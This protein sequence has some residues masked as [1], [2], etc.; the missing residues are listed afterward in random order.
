MGKDGVSVIVSLPGT[1][2]EADAADELSSTPY[3]PSRSNTPV[4]LTPI[5][6]NV[7]AKIMSEDNAAAEAKPKGMKK[8]VKDDGHNKQQLPPSVR[9]RR[10]SL[11][12]V[13]GGDSSDPMVQMQMAAKI[14]Q[15]AAAQAVSDGSTPRASNAANDDEDSTSGDFRNPDR[16]QYI[17]MPAMTML[18]M[19]LYCIMWGLWEKITEPVILCDPPPPVPPVDHNPSIEGEPMQHYVLNE[20]LGA[21]IGVV[22]IIFA[23]MYTSVYQDATERQ[24]HI[25]NALAQEAGGVHT[26]MLLVRTLDADD[27]INKT[28]G[29]LLFSSYI[30]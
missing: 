7:G 13:L 11:A 6:N 9:A 4:R 12:D 23:L 28:R 8:P 16:L 26:A 20:P 3:D 29:L 15:A 14:A 18:V 10:P 24:N 17:V 19:V 2:E 27:T 30:E 25:R 22:S 5:E 1:L 21:F